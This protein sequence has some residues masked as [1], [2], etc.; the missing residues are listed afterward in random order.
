MS[1]APRYLI[2][3]THPVFEGT[4]ERNQVSETPRNRGGEVFMTDLNK[5]LRNA[6]A[7]LTFD[8]PA[9]EPEDDEDNERQAAEDTSAIAL[10]MLWDF[11]E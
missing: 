11:V 6:M 10:L 4:H 1:D 3:P 9:D 7:S 2:S 8:E 5:L